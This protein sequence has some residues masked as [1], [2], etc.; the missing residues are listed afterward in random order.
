MSVSPSA[1]MSAARRLKEANTSG[2][3]VS[4]NAK[5][6]LFSRMST[7]SARRP[8]TA[9]SRSPS[10]S[11]FASTTTGNSA[12]RSSSSVP[13]DENAAPPLF[14]SSVS[15][16]VGVLC[17]D[18]CE[19]AVTVAVE[20]GRGDPVGPGADRIHGLRPEGA[21]AVVEQHAHVA[22][23][24]PEVRRARSRS[25]SPSRSASASR[26]GPWPPWSVVRVKVPFPLLK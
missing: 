14:R 17:L 19:V 18:H 8:E 24:A 23:L 22:G 15:S 5:L 3:S 10:P 9:R 25:P 16:A 20:V 21:V 26:V 11:Q 7:C 12:K 13:A 2:T 1:S 6:P 4:P